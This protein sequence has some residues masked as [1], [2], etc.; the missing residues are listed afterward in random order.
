MNASAQP[1]F[2]QALEAL[3]RG[4]RRSAAALLIREIRDGNTAQKNLPSVAQLAAHIGEIDVAIEASRRWSPGSIDGLRGYWAMLGTYGRSDE[5]LQDIRRQPVSIREHPSV[6]HIRGTI[7]NQFGRVEEAQD[8]FRRAIAKMPYAMQTWF[9][10]AMIKKFSP[11]DPDLAAME[12]LESI[13]APAEVRASLSY[14]LGKARQD[15]GD[16]DRAFAHYSHGAELIRKQRPFDMKGHREAVEAMIGES[17]KQAMD[18]LTP[19]RFEGQRSLFVTGLPRSGTTLT[20]QLLVG[21]PAV[22]DGAELNL[23][24]IALTPVLGLARE[25]ALRYQSSNGQDPWG[26]IARD[27]S[28]LLDMRFR[29]TDLVVDKSLGQTLLTGLILHSMPDARIA[30]LQRNPEDVALS[31]FRNYFTAGLAWTCSLTDIADYMRLEDRMLE[32]WK[33]VFPDR[34]LIVPYEELVRS[35]GEWSRRLQQHFGLPVE[36]GLETSLPMD[37]AVRTASVTQVKQPIST[38]RIGQAAAFERHLGPF[39]ERYYGRTSRERA[40]ADGTD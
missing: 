19:S 3:K 23:F 14:A 25:K 32:H 28:H 9:A 40:T 24:A 8:L 26:A 22:V 20:E 31:C 27:Y 18:E 17:G 37:R 16:A 10:L 12:R 30:W 5:A 29:S 33:A 1:F 21:H 2:L 36:A 4:D 34:I 7:V 15:C 39:R 38:S 6:L 11:G 35:P 13:D